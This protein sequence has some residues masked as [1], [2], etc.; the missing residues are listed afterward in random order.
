M[1]GKGTYFEVK[2]GQWKNIPFLTV[3]I[4]ILGL[5]L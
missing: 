5:M 4:E 3:I 1:H 2:V